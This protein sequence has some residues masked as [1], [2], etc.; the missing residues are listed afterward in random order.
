M[1][2]EFALGTYGEYLK[3]FYYLRLEMSSLQNSDSH[4]QQ[5]VR[6]ETTQDVRPPFRLLVRPPQFPQGKT[7]TAIETM[8]AINSMME[9]I[10]NQSRAMELQ[11]YVAPG[12]NIKRIVHFIFVNN[13]LIEGDQWRDRLI[14]RG[15]QNL[16]I[17]SSKSE[18]STAD[19]LNT[20]ITQG[21]YINGRYVQVDY[22]LMCTNAT[23]L[24]NFTGE[25]N[26]DSLLRRF[27]QFHPEIGVMC[28]FDEIDKYVRL[29]TDHIPKFQEFK[30]VLVL[31]GITAT[32]YKRFWDIMH[33]CGYY[34]VE[35]IGQLP[36]PKDYM[37]FNQ[38]EIIYTDDI[39]IKKPADNFK[40]FLENPGHDLEYT[41]SSGEMVMTKLPDL[42]ANTGAIIFVPGEPARKSHMEI[43]GIALGYDKNALVIN[44]KTK[45]FYRA[46]DDGTPIEIAEY[47]K[48]QIKRQEKEI[49]EGTQIPEG[50]LFVNMTAM[51]VAVKM[52]ND[53]A[54]GLKDADLVITGFYCVERGVTFNR[55]DFQFKY[56]I[57][58]PFH[59]KE[60]SKEIESIIQ[61]AGR[62]HG[63]KEF[64]RQITILAPQYIVETVNKAIEDLI[65]FLRDAAPKS[66]NH[67]SIFRE[68]NGI[69]IMCNLDDDTVEQLIRIGKASTREK[70]L[71]C[72]AILR[73][74]YQ[75]GKFILEDK[76]KE[77]PNYKPF[78]FDDYSFDGKRIAEDEAKL[79][80]YRFSSFYD[81]FLKQTIYGQT[82]QRGQYTVDIAKIA[83]KI[84]D[85]LTL[86]A[87]TAFI[88]FG[89]QE[90]IV[91]EE[92]D[93]ANNFE[94]MVN[95]T[96]IVTTSNAASSSST[97]SNA[98]PKPTKTQIRKEKEWIA[99][100]M[101]GGM[102]EE[103]A[104]AKL[105]ELKARAEAMKNER[106]H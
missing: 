27:Q 13:N 95:T 73:K 5:R 32:P 46:C 44:G 85:E 81:S 77:L 36:D 11:N 15:V 6:G 90:R 39:T 89:F 63:S 41:T 19:T 12:T 52:Y 84:N 47:K 3:T 22:V 91:S 55:P 70:K 104:K 87:G 79:K 31:N 106:N 60:D 10:F 30:N 35:L 51:D 8:K 71:Q 14:R 16:K 59:Y 1:K 100:L 26:G 29:L 17:F 93:A 56:A 50:D 96:N 105:E 103:A 21:Q 37:T 2:I 74:A 53:P 43:A 76:N 4:W 75:D 9:W 33:E 64:V 86:P 102:T 66:I 24:G 72:H 7:A 67:A 20:L 48:Q 92:E 38:H 61:L 83:V 54:L 28:W 78:S 45:A 58:T 88:S 57:L 69:P 65:S 18:V 68:T 80:S 25:A 94:E 40:F 34:D 23:R 42:S 82:I 101:A 98:A 99:G 62:T 97:T 49:R